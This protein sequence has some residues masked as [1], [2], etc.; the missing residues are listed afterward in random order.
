MN[1]HYTWES[2]TFYPDEQEQIDELQR[3]YSFTDAQIETFAKINKEG[4]PVFDSAQKKKLIRAMKDYGPDS[5]EVK[6]LSLLTKDGN[7]VWRSSAM[8][9]FLES[10]FKLSPTEMQWLVPRDGAPSFF[11]FS[12]ALAFSF[13][14]LNENRSEEEIRHCVRIFNSKGGKEAAKSVIVDFLSPTALHVDDFGQLLYSNSLSQMFKKLKKVNFREDILEYMLQKDKHDLSMVKAAC[15]LYN[16]TAKNNEL[17]SL[18]NLRNANG[19]CT[20]DARRCYAII[21]AGEQGVKPED[22]L[23]YCVTD[24]KGVPILSD[25]DFRYCLA[26]LSYF[27]EDKSLAEATLQKALTEKSLISEEEMEDR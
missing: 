7:P 4:N 11:G 2:H 16:D 9:G 14:I 10:D 3:K 13:L 6:F 5:E 22:I 24:E 23:K 27:P 20:F 8:A 25:R 17:I 15:K 12:D 26:T 21:E 18:I 19:E 1:E